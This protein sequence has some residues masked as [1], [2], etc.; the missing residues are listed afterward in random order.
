MA[1]LV[2]S[3]VDKLLAQFSKIKGIDAPEACFAGAEVL[4]RKSMEN[5]PVKTGFL[6]QSHTSVK[7]EEGAQMQVQAEYA[8]F[9]ELGT[10]KWA[11]KP[12]VRPAIDSEQDN[13]L[14]AIKDNLKQQVD[15][16]AS[17]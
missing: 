14:K 16:L 12:F 1:E 8:P 13:I 9:V 17:E 11:G 15:D 5:S 4:Q 7:T 10:S 6:R 2:I 3:G